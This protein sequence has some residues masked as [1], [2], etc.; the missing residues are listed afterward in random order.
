MTGSAGTSGWDSGVEEA[1]LKAFPLLQYRD[2]Y[3]QIL[4]A[5][6]SEPAVSAGLAALQEATKGQNSVAFRAYLNA[7][8]TRFGFSRDVQQ[9]TSTDRLV[10]PSQFWLYLQARRPLTDIGAGEVHG[11]L[12]HQVQWVL[13]GQWNDRNDRKI[14]PTDRIGELYQNLA[15]ANARLLAPE[16]AEQ[17]RTNTLAVPINTAHG[18]VFKAAW[19]PLVDHTEISNARMPEHL[20]YYIQRNFPELHGRMKL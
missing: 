7:Q 13:I 9:I 16:L 19:D 8:E 3:L 6:S 14:G 17:V 12:T 15:R 1:A 11:P 20:T 18:N 10:K 5:L 2:E 4:Q